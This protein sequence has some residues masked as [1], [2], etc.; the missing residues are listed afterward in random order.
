MDRSEELAPDYL[1][2]LSL[3]PLTYEPD[4]R[5]P[6]DFVIDGRIAVEV[7]RLNQNHETD[8]GYEGL[9]SVEAA[10]LR[11]VEKLL[12]RYGPAPA[13]AGWWVSFDFRRPVDGKT[14]KRALPLALEAFKASPSP[15]GADIRLTRTFELEI[16]P[17]SIPVEHLFM[18]GGYMDY[19][20]GGFV[21]GEIIR[22]LNLCI[23][24][25]AAK[26]E[27]YRARYREWWLVLPDHIGPDLNA[28]ER[29]A[30]GKHV[31]IRSFARVVLVHPRDPAR[32]LVIARRPP[33]EAD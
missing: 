15:N 4:G 26:I 16:R 25:K 28:D 30:I 31:D 20:A 14:V 23:A 1:R 10:L 5:I 18:L 3:G 7:R 13:A 27:P 32:S 8:D 29:D 6:P 17:A 24:E 12:P 9:E 11:F 21:A 2:S 33:G 19:D 22:N